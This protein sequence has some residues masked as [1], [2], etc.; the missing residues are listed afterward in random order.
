MD[1]EREIRDMDSCVEDLETA[2]NNLSGIKPTYL[3]AMNTLI[4]EW[5]AY[6]RPCMEN[7]QG[8]LEDNGSETE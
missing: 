4:D 5:R 8:Q 6:T 7:M 1:I 3:N 2:L